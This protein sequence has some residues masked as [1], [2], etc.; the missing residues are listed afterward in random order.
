MAKL[1]F[2]H[3]DFAGKTYKLFL[4]KTSI[5]R[6]DANV[7][8]IRHDSVSARHCEI[9][10]Y[11]TEVIVRDLDSSNGTFVDGAKLHN[12]QT[13][14]KSGQVIRF[15]AVDARLEIETSDNIEGNTEM[16]AIVSHARAVRD[17]RRAK[18]NPPPDP[19]QVLESEH[20]PAPDTQTILVPKQ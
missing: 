7:L 6:S 12:Q 5:G 8:V 9:L 15:G 13:A 14:V 19:A 3:P 11:G 10:V 1:L 2:T 16:T 17:Q 18:A 20:H 4:E